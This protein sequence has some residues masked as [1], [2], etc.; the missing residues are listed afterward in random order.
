MISKKAQIGINVKFGESVTIEDDVIIG[1][2]VE[3]GSCVFIGNGARI[4]DGVKIF[5]GACVSG[6]PQDLKFKGEFSTTEIGRNTVI[7]EFATIHRGT[8]WSYKTIIGENCLLMAY[9]HTAHDCELGKN[10]ILA[11][12]CNLAGHI[13]ID[14]YA[15]LGGLSAVVQFNN[16]GK[17]VMVAGGVVIRKDIPPFI[18]VSHPEDVR[19]SGINIVGLKR[20]GFSVER[21]RKIRDI[22]KIIFESKYN[23]GDAL[24]KVKDEFSPD[25]D[26]N[27][28]VNFI[29]SSKN[30]IVKGFL[31]KR[32]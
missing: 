26:L 1:N 4:N 13:K 12:A 25:E 8:A 17:H 6:I 20:R 23:V 32:N 18:L 5:H 27:E 14:D 21:I 15:I 10:V 29:E 7:R 2:N 24:K 22:Y 16:I 9:S 28:I 30:G 31:D 3:I 11:N 19:Y